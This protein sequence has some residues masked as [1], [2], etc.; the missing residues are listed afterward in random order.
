MRATFL[1]A[2]T[3]AAKPKLIRTKNR[4]WV[5]VHLLQQGPRVVVASKHLSHG[6]TGRAYPAFETVL[7]LVNVQNLRKS[8]LG[9]SGYRAF[10]LVEPSL[11]VGVAIDI[12][13]YK[14]KGSKH[15]SNSNTVQTHFYMVNPGKT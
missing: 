8:L 11:V 14:R 15:T 9:N 13:V 3:P 7:E 4:F 1:A 2:V 5:E 10:Q 12:K 6:T